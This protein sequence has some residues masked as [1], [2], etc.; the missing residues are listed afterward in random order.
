[1]LNA[2]RRLTRWPWFSR[3]AKANHGNPTDWVWV[4]PEFVVPPMPLT[5]NERLAQIARERDALKDGLAKAIRDKK[6]RSPYY[7]ALRALTNEELALDG[8][9]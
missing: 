1:M 3:P 8:G 5:K 7:K 9:K 2:L 6:A 4:N